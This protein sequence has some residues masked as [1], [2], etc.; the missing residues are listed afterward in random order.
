MTR[1]RFRRIAQT[2][3]QKTAIQILPR[4]RVTGPKFSFFFHPSTILPRRVPLCMAIGIAWKWIGGNRR[5]FALRAGKIKWD[6][7]GFCRP[8]G[9]LYFAGQFPRNCHLREA[10]R[11]FAALSRGGCSRCTVRT[12]CCPLAALRAACRDSRL[13]RVVFAQV[14]RGS[15]FR[16]DDRRAE[17]LRALGAVD[18][19]LVAA[20]NRVEAQQFARFVDRID[21]VAGH[22]CR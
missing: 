8:P 6:W 19:R 15:S 12:V 10:I 1:E 16:C 2:P 13:V 21:A 17:R 3:A 22:R 9:K 5:S 14:R 7:C 18:H 20:G 11:R 4:A